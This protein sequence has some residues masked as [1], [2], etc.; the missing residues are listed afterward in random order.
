MR[1][2]ERCGFLASES[3]SVNVESSRDAASLRHRS[4]Q[5]HPDCGIKHLIGYLVSLGQGLF[6]F[7]AECRNR[8]HG[9]GF[10]VETEEF[11][12]A[13]R[14]SPC[15]KGAVVGHPSTDLVARRDNVDQNTSRSWGSARMASRTACRIERSVS[16]GMCKTSYRTPR[17][18]GNE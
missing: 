12:R 13:L 4:A 11:E 6:G 18:A 3:V 10:E 7:E 9:M 16:V 17:S 8:S 15:T 1:I 14:E 5:T 2:V